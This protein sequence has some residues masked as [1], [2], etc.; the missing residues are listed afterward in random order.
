MRSASVWPLAVAGSLLLAGCQGASLN[1][2]DVVK[3]PVSAHAAA[4]PQEDAP[5][6]ADKASAAEVDEKATASVKPSANVID[7]YVPPKPGTVLTW[8]NN[9]STLPPVISYKVA[10]IVKA[11]DKE[12]VKLTS[13]AGLGETVNAYYDTSNFA[14]KGYR[15]ARDKAMLT[16]KP[17]E[18]RYRFPLQPGDKWVTQWKSF[19]HRKKA[20]TSGGGVVEVIG[21][22]M[23]KLPAGTFRTVKVKMPT[24]PGMPAGMRHYLWFA[25]DLGVTVKEQIGNG[26]MN[27]SQVLEK[28]QYPEG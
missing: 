16:F 20:E 8:R 6:E 11:G 21:F 12:Y 22:E 14:L 26:S 17:V 7:S 5:Q 25:P 10:G 13:V 15:D 9:W 19:D 2:G 1:A 28:V 27:W 23:L 24:P 3:P 18:E 4:A